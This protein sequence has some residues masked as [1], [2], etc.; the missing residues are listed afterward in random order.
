MNE[1]EFIE[2]LGYENVSFQ[3]KDRHAAYYDA[4]GC[5]IQIEYEGGAVNVKPEGSE[6]WICIGER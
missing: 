3:M 1:I 2:S 5:E 4:D 6:D